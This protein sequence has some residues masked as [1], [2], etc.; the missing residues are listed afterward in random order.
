MGHSLLS[1]SKSHRYLHC[2]ASMWVCKD[3]EG[4]DNPSEYALE[5][6]IAHAIFSYAVKSIFMEIPEPGTVL[7]LDINGEVVQVTVAEEH[8]KYLSKCLE[9]LVEIANGRYILSEV[10]LDL[11]AVLGVAGQTGTADIIIEG[12]GELVVVDLKWG[13]G[14]SVEAE[15]NT[16]LNIYAAGALEL[17]YDKKVET[18]RQFIFQPRRDSF[19]S[20]VFNRDDF[21][22]L[23]T[24]I[25][26]DAQVAAV[27]YNMDETPGEEL[28]YVEEET[29]RW[30]AGNEIQVDGSLLCPVRDKYVRNTLAFEL[31]DAANVPTTKKEREEAVQ[32]LDTAK[33]GSI[34]VAAPL[35]RKYLD[36]VEDLA[37]KL[38]LDGQ[39]F[40]G[41][42][43]VQGK[44]GNRAW[45]DDAEAESLLK[46]MKLKTDEMYKSTLKSPTQIAEVLDTPSSQRRW[47]KVQELIV[48][49]PGKLIMVPESD[50]RVE[51]VVNKTTADELAEPVQLIGTDAPP[52]D[53]DPVL[54]LLEVPAENDL[55]GGL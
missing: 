35:I 42:K 23:M 38:A 52:A 32:S 53:P 28:F 36:E 24:K 37:Y 1:P 43:L 15:G 10:T 20:W 2:P 14:I 19:K 11:S 4:E 21:G 26:K 7:D 13:Q 54:G 41:V 29:C 33:I 51:V 31:S 22:H 27:C 48:R 46:T 44:E 16:Q 30:C 47:K 17:F 6:T 12:D 25:K 39:K 40:P 45:R 34:V 18:I 3:H 49:A 50:K 5:G 8:H 9:K 55:L